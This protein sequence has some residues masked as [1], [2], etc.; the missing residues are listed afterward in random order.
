MVDHTCPKC[1]KVFTRIDSYYYHINKVNSCILSERPEKTQY[2][3]KLLNLDDKFNDLN[4][5]FDDLSRKFIA[6]NA[7]FEQLISGE[8]CYIQE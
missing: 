3:T 6:L 4:A 8:I 7:K 5:K 2:K 1:S